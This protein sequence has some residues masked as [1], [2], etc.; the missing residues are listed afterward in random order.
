MSDLPG[1]GDVVDGFRIGERFHAGGMGV[2]YR[3]TGPD[4]GFPMIMKI[5]RLGP[6]EPASSVIS[7]EVEQTVLAALKG[8]HVP[9]FVA[10]G[11]LERQPYLVMEEVRGRSLKEWVADGPVPLD[12]V[13]RIGIALATALH[14]LHQQEAI[15]LDLKPA[16]VVFRPTGEA[17]LVDFGLAH[18]AHYPDLLA[19]EFRRPIGSAP[20]IAPEQVVGARSDPRSDLFA[21]GAVLYEL[22]TGR[23]PFGAPTTP[24]GLRRRLYRDPTPPRALVPALPEWF[25]ELVLRCLEPDASRRHASAAQV[26]FDLA[27]PD[28]VAITE[29]GRRR[30]AAGPLTVLRR[31]I[32]AAGY[33]PAP[34]ALPSTELSGAAIVLACIA[35]QHTNE[36]QFEAIRQTVRRLLSL[37]DARRLA[38]ATVIRPTPE[39][40]GSSAHETAAHQRIKHLALLRHWAEPLALEAGQVSLHVIESGDPAQ[41]LVDYARA[42][43]VE[44][45]VIGAPPPDVPLRGI[46]G[47]VA[48]KVALEAPCT[49]TL[50]RPP[51][52]R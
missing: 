38:V 51:G 15:H 25:Q 50:V 45:L 3:V 19:E 43:G 33:E 18:H 8:P 16:N 44:H 14:D 1:P 10:A 47:T 42:N 7:F 12:E 37:Q 6:G 32:K 21:L 4:P 5:P 46:L 20:Y 30:R 26:A 29:R 24:G 2:I 52:R 41:A 11:D 40:G 27:H 22:A 49:V 35:T 34:L 23:L 31:W 13:V 28:Q 48:T 36:A 9:R 17:V 39:L